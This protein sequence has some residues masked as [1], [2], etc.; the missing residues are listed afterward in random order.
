MNFE[1]A[2]A[3]AREDVAETPALPTFASI[4]AGLRWAEPQRRVLRPVSARRWLATGGAAIALLTMLVDAG[5]GVAMGTGLALTLVAPVLLLGLSIVGIHR[6]RLGAQLGARAIWWSY[7]VF[8]VVWASGPAES[9][10]AGGALLAVGCGFALLAAG[11][12]GLTRRA[13]AAAFDPV[14]FRRTVLLSMILAVSDAQMLAL[15]GITY[16]EAGVVEGHPAALLT[17]AALLLVGAWGLSRLRVWAVALNVVANVL[18]VVLAGFV[19]GRDSLLMPVLGVSALIQLV[20][21]ARMVLAFRRGARPQDRG[22]ELSAVFGVVV[23]VILVCVAVVLGL[24]GTNSL[25]S[26]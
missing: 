10:P 3:A 21:P 25:S 24:V 8:A 5:I 2:L 14:A 13:T 18:V 12:Q 16:A 17:S 26:H 9:L 6:G 15:L 4:D 23:V 7:L 11:L 1:Q 20:L 22:T 19:I